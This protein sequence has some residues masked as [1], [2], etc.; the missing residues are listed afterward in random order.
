[1]E[2]NMYGDGHGRQSGENRTVSKYSEIR[3][4]RYY[5]SVW[6]KEQPF[7]KAG[8][9]KQQ[10]EEE[11]NYLNNHLDSFYAGSYVPL[12]KQSVYDMWFK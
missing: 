12:W 8:M 1:M 2:N 7:Y 6:V 11:I 4:E 3:Y 9:S 5:D 10:I